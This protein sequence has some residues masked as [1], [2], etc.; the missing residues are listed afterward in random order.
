MSTLPLVTVIIPVRDGVAGLALCL[1]ALARQ[2]YPAEL[3]EVIVVDN[4]STED[5]RPAL[6]VDPRFTMIREDRPGS[7]VARNAGI[8]R[9]RGAVLAFTDGDCIPAPTWIERGVE[10]LVAEP[11]PDAVGGRVRMTFSAGRPA[12][13][14]QHYEDVLGFPQRR[15]IEKLSF[16]ATANLLAWRE[17]FDRVGLF[18]PDLRSGGDLNW[19]RRL[20][21]GGGTMHYAHDAV[22]DHP[23]RDTW[24]ELGR[25]TVRVA[26]GLA[27][28][29]SEDERATRRVLHDVGHEARTAASIWWRVWRL[30]RPTGL[31][32][33][34]QFAAATSYVRLLR[35]RV[36]VEDLR[37][38]RTRTR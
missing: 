31:R 4:G 1:A 9:S 8:A 38:A 32:G 21:A 23:S 27:D 10:E 29:R 34:L 14:P 36:R 12:N 18:D 37:R 35:A 26:Q 19:G 17:A 30:P 11:R 16:S 15:Y 13:G 25:K 20:A 33:K 6:P 7:Y 28:Q 22:V 2:T 24:G 5:L 3:F